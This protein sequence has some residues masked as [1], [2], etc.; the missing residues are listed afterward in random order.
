MEVLVKNENEFRS[1]RQLPSHSTVERLKNRPLPPPIPGQQPPSSPVPLQQQPIS[2]MARGKPLPG[3]PSNHQGKQFERPIFVKSQPDKQSKGVNDVKKMKKRRGLPRKSAGYNG[4]SK[5]TGPNLTRSPANPNSR[6]SNPNFQ[7]IQFQKES[8]KRMSSAPSPQYSNVNSGQLTAHTRD[9]LEST[10]RKTFKLNE[11]YKQICRCGAKLVWTRAEDC[12]PKAKEVIG[13][14]CRPEAKPGVT[15][16]VVCC[17]ICKKAMRKTDFVYHCVKPSALHPTGY[18]VCGPCII[19][20]PEKKQIVREQLKNNPDLRYCRTR[21]QLLV[22]ALRQDTLEVDIVGID[23]KRPPGSGRFGTKK[24]YYTVKVDTGA[25]TWM[26]PYRYS[27]FLA[28]H[29]HMQ[30]M[31]KCVC[32]GF[33]RKLPRFPNQSLITLG[34]TEKKK[35]KQMTVF[36]AY[37]EGLLRNKDT[38]DD[39]YLSLFLCKD[40]DIVV[41]K[42][43]IDDNLE[44]PGEE[45]E[46]GMVYHAYQKQLNTEF[47]SKDIVLQKAKLIKEGS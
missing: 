36:R 27:E 20:R 19:A 6:I 23:M 34:E 22:L 32:I 35:N 10:S 33:G 16:R 43:T 26:I 44:T 24:C 37:L 29:E 45:S 13:A 12:Y 8:G 47:L 25:Y 14:G 4:E 31:E 11:N 30:K 7:R 46:K 9:S 42:N 15:S 18:D 38:R 17:D 21:K 41:R 28:L 40:P 5:E 39:P 3:F 1:T 2:G